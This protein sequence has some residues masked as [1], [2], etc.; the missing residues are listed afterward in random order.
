M[1]DI[2]ARSQPNSGFLDTI[3]WKS[4]VSYFVN[5][6]PV[7]AELVRAEIQKDGNGEAN[8]RFL[9]LYERA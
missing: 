6:R 3:T 7:W 5:I 4:P 2:F 9:R 1:V 8:R